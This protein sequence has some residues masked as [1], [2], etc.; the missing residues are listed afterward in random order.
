VQNAKDTFYEVLR[1]RLAALNP[2]RTIVLRGVTRPGVLVDE[3]ELVTD[4]A[5]P[6]CFRMQWAKT[7][8]DG[9]PG[10]AEGDNERNGRP[11]IVCRFDVREFA[12]FLYPMSSAQF[13]R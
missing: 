9:L 7:Q 5:E 2:D 10:W 13:S 1:G 11:V 12:C 6:D 8:V 3:N 4:V